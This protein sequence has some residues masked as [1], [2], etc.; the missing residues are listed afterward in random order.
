MP[1]HISIHQSG[2]DKIMPTGSE[3]QVGYSKT[4]AE[5]VRVLSRF[6]NIVTLHTTIHHRILKLAQ[7]VQIS[8]VN[9]LIDNTHLYQILADILTYEE[10]CKPIARKIFAWI[11]ASNNVFYSLVKATAL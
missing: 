1:S 9:P 7:Y 6:M 4:I 11:V 3:M 2:T 5:T 10:H 8:I